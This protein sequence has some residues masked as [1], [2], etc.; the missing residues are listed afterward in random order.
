MAVGE[1]RI[2]DQ[3]VRDVLKAK[4]NL[5]FA[6]FTRNPSNMRL[7]LEIR[8]FDDRIADLDSDL[9]TKMQGDSLSPN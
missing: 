2:D 6:D 9:A 8:L 5:L 4:R 1:T 3:K 7:V